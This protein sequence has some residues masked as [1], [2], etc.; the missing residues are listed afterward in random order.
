MGDCGCA[1]CCSGNCAGCGSCGSCSVGCSGYV[2]LQP[3]DVETDGRGG[4]AL[5][6]GLEVATPRRRRGMV[7]FGGEREEGVMFAV[8]G[9]GIGFKF[10]K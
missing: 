5:A 2:I 4:L 9:M 3:C 6:T 10:K 7:I 1:N 8:I